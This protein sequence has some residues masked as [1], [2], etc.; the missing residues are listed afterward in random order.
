MNDT[1]YRELI[2]I[3]KINIELDKMKNYYDGLCD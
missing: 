3:R 2:F 1:D